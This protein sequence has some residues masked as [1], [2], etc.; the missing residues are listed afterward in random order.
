MKPFACPYCGKNLRGLHRELMRSA[1][2]ADRFAVLCIKCGEPVFLDV[3]T[4]FRKP[5]DDEFGELVSRP[6]YHRS[7][8]AFL[9]IKRRRDKGEPMH[10]DEMWMKFRVQAL[11]DVTDDA[12]LNYS[13]HCFLSGVAM[14]MSYFRFIGT[15]EMDDFSARLALIEAEL[16]AYKETI[17]EEPRMN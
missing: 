12:Q 17:T 10:L 4:G 8:G 3:E 7:R 5:T 15:L 1:P 6:E 16:E 9:E 2:E 11:R 14:A 13:L